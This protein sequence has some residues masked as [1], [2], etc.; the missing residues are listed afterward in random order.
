MWARRSIL[1]DQ[2]IAS[3]THSRWSRWL[4]S[5]GLGIVCGQLTVLLLGI[6][7]VVI[8]AT[9]DGASALLRMDDVRPFFDAP[10]VVHL[11]FY[12]LIPVLFLFALNTLLCT[13]ETTLRLWRAGRRAPWRHGPALIHLSF[14]VALLAHLVGG[15]WSVEKP[16]V[17]VGDVWTDL[18]DGRQARVY[19]I[20]VQRHAN[21]QPK[22]IEAHLQLR[23]K[24]AP[25]KIWRESVG[26]NEPLTSALGSRLLLLVRAGYDRVA[27]VSDGQH[28]C[29][30][31]ARQLCQLGKRKLVVLS[32]SPA[33]HWGNAPAVRV[34]I[35]DAQKRGA[36]FFLRP[37]RT[38]RL[39][40]GTQLQL[41]RVSVSPMVILRRRQTP[42]VPWALL[43][44]LMLLLGMVLMGRRWFQRS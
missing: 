38:H 28:V 15:L 12:L 16:P 37:G 10:S 26:Y 23:H 19:R 1:G 43:S 2:A 29:T 35:P 31:P 36:P 3:E 24:R 40:D 5:Q 42:G 13:W 32:I 7:S 8:A 18:G 20:K 11:W 22:Q 4:Y 39:H 30:S 33:G 14:L 17:V 21:R 44:A 41:Q 25:K 27:V 6:G 9:R 34:M